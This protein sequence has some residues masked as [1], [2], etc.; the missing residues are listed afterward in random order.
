MPLFF[1]GFA[2]RLHTEHHGGNCRGQH[3]CKHDDE[4][5]HCDSPFAAVQVPECDAMRPFHPLRGLK[6]EDSRNMLMIVAVI[7]SYIR[8]NRQVF[9]DTRK[10]GGDSGTENAGRG[11]A[12]V[13]SLF[14]TNKKP[15]DLWFTMILLSSSDG[16]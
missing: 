12:A 3:D 14:L 10:T 13:H 8:T 4:L 5:F 9:G 1:A 2:E 16:N 11:T 6:T 15:C 7:I